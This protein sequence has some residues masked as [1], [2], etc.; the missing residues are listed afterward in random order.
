VK[1]TDVNNSLSGLIFHSNQFKKSLISIASLNNFVIDGA[2]MVNN[3]KNDGDRTPELIQFT[4]STATLSGIYIG[5]N[6]DSTTQQVLSNSS[7][8]SEGVIS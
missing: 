5:Y 2:V 8:C 6:L 4:Q 7:G 3:L 1:S